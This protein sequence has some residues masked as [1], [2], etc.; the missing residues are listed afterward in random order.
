[1]ISGEGSLFTLVRTPDGD[2]DAWL[3]QRR[4]GIGGSDVAAIMGLSPWRGAYEVWAEKSG[5]I[6]SPDISDKPSVM[7][8]NILEPVVGEHYADNHPD[9]EVRRVNAVCQSIERPWAQ[10]SLDYEVKDP[11]LG[12]GILEIKTAGF[13]SAGEWDD[14]VPLFYLT[15]VTHYMDVTGRPFADVAVLIGGQDYR[16]YRI[17]R[18]EDD[19]KSVHEAVDGFWSKVENGEAPDIDGSAGEA[20]ALFRRYPSSKGDMLS[21]NETPQEVTDFIYYKELADSAKKRLNTASDALK[22]YIGDNR[23]VA[24][25]NRVI[26]WSRGTKSSFDEKSFRNDHPELYDKYIKTK[27]ANFGLRVNERKS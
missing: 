11:D 21:P 23:G 27:A 10:A 9:R 19:I 24:C 20:E 16:E 14:G 3:A 6:E 4:K 25:G 5:L 13:R 2:R 17:M 26:T 15:Q 18:D 8:G 7:W 12:W 1:M 22:E